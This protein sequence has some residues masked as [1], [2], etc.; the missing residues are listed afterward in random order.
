[1]DPEQTDNL[2]PDELHPSKKGKAIIGQEVISKPGAAIKVTRLILSEEVN[3]G[4]CTTCKSLPG[5]EKPKTFWQ[6]L[7]ERL[8]P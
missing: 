2:D 5:I 6:W 1:M 4:L 3:K 8:K 7:F